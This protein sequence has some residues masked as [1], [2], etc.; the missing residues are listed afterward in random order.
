[1]NK[2][3]ESTGFM[4][5][6]KTIAVIFNSENYEDEVELQLGNYEIAVRDGKTYA[7]RKKPVYPETYEECCNIVG[8]IAFKRHLQYDTIPSYKFEEDLRDSLE[9]LR[10]LIICR[11]AY[12]KIAGEEIKLDKPW[13]P[14]WTNYDEYKYCLYINED[15][16]T[17]GTFYTVNKILSF[18][19]VEM[20]NAF[21]ENFKNE[22]EQCKELL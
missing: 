14:D 16:I 3:I 6:G 4:Q 9:I 1:M 2:K 12:W 18:P 17:K 21:Y 19:T 11:N 15:V 22:I 8:G 5:M 10:K 13:A 20:R 7:V